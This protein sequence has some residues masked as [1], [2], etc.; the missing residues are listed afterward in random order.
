VASRRKGERLKR[1]S[2]SA[3]RGEGNKIGIEDGAS[4]RERER[5]RER[6]MIR[7]RN[8]CAERSNQ[9][10]RA[11]SIFGFFP[12]HPCEYISRRNPQNPGA[13]DSLNF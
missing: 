4:E 8:E 3:R 1:T 13:R 5:E 2:E 10:L 12:Q 6:E 7:V 11:L 9:E